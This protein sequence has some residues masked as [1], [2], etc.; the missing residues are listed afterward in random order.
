[1][2]QEPG[3]FDVDSAF[4]QLRGVEAEPKP[5]DGLRPIVMNAGSSPAGKAFGIAHADVLFRNWRSLEAN[6]AD[7]AETVAAAAAGGREIGLYT[8]GYIIC[9]PTRNEAQ[10]YEH[11]VTVEHPDVVAIDHQV[12]LMGAGNHALRNMSPEAIAQFRRRMAAGAG[13]CPIVGD[14]DEV[15]AGLAQLNAAG[16]DGFA[17]SF[18]NYV[19]EFP[20]FRDEVLP[21]LERVGLRAVN[22]GG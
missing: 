10:E 19:D 12:E 22:S 3:P 11:Y 7:N 8:S 5:V 14:P 17:F 9:R 21:R 15:V 6:A 20:F 18:V 13:G 16:F 4:F 1:M 2:W